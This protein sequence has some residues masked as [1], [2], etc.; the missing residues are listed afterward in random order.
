MRKLLPYAVALPL[1]LLAGCSTMNAEDCLNADWEVIGM[2]D[3]EKG[4]LQSSI[5]DYNEQCGKHKVTP[6]KKQYM[7]GYGK[8]LV[9]FCTKESGFA[10]GKKNAKNNSLCK[11]DSK[12]AFNDGF[13][14]GQ[15][16]FAVKKEISSLE[17][18]IRGNKKSIE[19]MIKS[20]KK[21]KEAISE[22]EDITAARKEYSENY[23]SAKA[24]AVTLDTQ[25]D[26]LSEK[27]AV[28]KYQYT[29]LVKKYGYQ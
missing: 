5:A 1:L 10:E 13:T 6:N 20:L 16:Y 24:K 2:K 7:F 9:V 14:I 3:G 29:E 27:L 19:R 12:L 17:S 25:S 11:G 8:G 28:K 26:Y 22:S 18:T 4:K 21:Q 23:N 15:E